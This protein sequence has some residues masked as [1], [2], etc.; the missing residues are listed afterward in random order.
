MKLLII[1]HARHGKDTVAELLSKYAPLKFESSSK[2]I[3]PLVNKDLGYDTTEACYE[4]RSN[5]RVYWHD[6]IAKYN[7]PDPSKLCRKILERN[8]MYVGMRALREY[9]ETKN[10]FDLII[11]VE[12]GLRLPPEP[13]SSNQM[14][15]LHADIIICNNGS[16]SD[17][18]YRVSA[19]ARCLI[20]NKG[21]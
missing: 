12:A 13:L 5:H 8:D 3:A 18:D 17:L 11:W 9:K 14:M 7:T 20:C 6:W 15:S 1:G 10:L 16:D 21:L 4:D 19:L 2:F